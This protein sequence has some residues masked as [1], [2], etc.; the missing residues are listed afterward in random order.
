[1]N[2]AQ[3][4]FQSLLLI[5]YLI[6][7]AL[8]IGFVANFGVNTP[9]HDQWRL[10]DFFEKIAT[11]HI[12]FIDVWALHSNHRIVFP[13]IIITLLA[14]ASQWNIH[15]ELC[16]NIIF[17]SLSF[18][19][20]YKIAAIQTP[21]QQSIVFHL[22]NILTGALNFYLVQQENWLWG[23]QLA[24]FLV[25]L[26]MILAIFVLTSN[27]I[28][29]QNKG[30]LAAICCGI[31]S[32]SL[33]QGLL[34]WLAV[35]PS[36]WVL[37][38]NK[39]QRLKN[40]G[41]WFILFLITCAI[42]AIDYHPQRQ[43]KIFLIFQKPLVTLTYFFNLLGSA[44]VRIPLISAVAGLIILS[45]FFWLLFQFYQK[46]SLLNSRTAP[47]ISLGLFSILSSL[48]ITMGRVEYGANHAI[49]SS[50]YTTAAIL[51]LIAM[52][53]LGRL[54][55]ELF[56]PK[57]R[58][59]RF[60]QLAAGVLVSLIILNSGAAI[61]QAQ[62]ALPYRKSSQTCLELI[63]YLEPSNFFDGSPDSCL[64]VLTEKTGLI[65]E[66]APILEKLGWRKLAQNVTFIT[67]PA[68]IYGYL[69]HP[70][71]AQESLSVKKS[72]T[73]QLSG[74]AIFPDKSQQPSLVW[75][76]YGTQKSFFANAYVN[77]D[78]PD[79]AQVLHSNRYRRARWTVKFPANSL[80]L[81]K[82]VI[83]A[84]V[85]NPEDNQFVKLQSDASVIVINTVEEE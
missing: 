21:H 64:W 36:I 20:Y 6:P 68:S 72:D 71:T 50:R 17:S 22:V 14:F 5:L 76:S 43:T 2:L 31:A 23:F 19:L 70:Q 67:T 82:T 47:W 26:C 28:A 12:T 9:I 77:L 40:L 58:G 84:W 32:F 24:W 25:N 35:I 75:L 85:Y 7:L 83:K 65:R 44:V 61:V 42:Y 27:Q 8:L 59:Q 29:T 80:P 60:Y 16:L 33:A 37:T 74:W 34:S 62:T 79:I 38:E 30:L 53:Q 49:L 1:M 69:D 81:G 45:S 56:K 78:S 54:L 66:K 13:K 48:F 39:I 57:A 46:K 18:F 63:N 41:G 3:R 15:Y 11:G 4:K 51:L 73:L 10:I 52:V 55:L